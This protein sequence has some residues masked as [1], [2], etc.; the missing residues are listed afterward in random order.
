[1]RTGAVLAGD[2]N[3]DCWSDLVFT[4]GAIASG[5]LM[6]YQNRAGAGF[7]QALLNVTATS[8]PFAGAGIADLDG[9]Y[10]LDLALGNLLTGDTRTY[11]G[12]GAGGFTLLQSLPMSRSTFGFAFG[13]YSGDEWPDVFAAHWDIEPPPTDSPA[14]LINLGTGSA[15][16]DG[17]LV[18]MDVAAG[19]TSADLPQDFALSP[20]FVDLNDDQDADLLIAADFATSQVLQNTGTQSYSVITSS[21]PLS[22]QNAS[23]H[24]IAD[25]DNDGLWD[26]F[27]ASVHGPGDSRPWPWGIQGNKLYFGDNSFPFLIAAGSATGTED[28]EWPWGVCA[29]DFDNDGLTDL[30]VETGFGDAPPAVMA[31]ESTDPFIV[32]INESLFDKQLTR[33][34]LFINQGNRTFIDQASAWGID[35]PTNGRG[36]A[37]LDYDRDGDIDIAI[38]QNSGPALLY[39]NQHSADDGNHFLSLRLL[40]V[41]PNTHAIGA[42]VTVEAGGQTQ[43]QQVSANSNFLGQD[44]YDLHFGLGQETTIDALTVRWP[45]GTNESY[46]QMPVNKFMG[47]YDPRM[48]SYPTTA[49]L[50]RID[51]AITAALGYVDTPGQLASDI[52]LGLSWM[53]R[54]HQISLPYSPGDV[55]IARAVDFENQ[56]R[57][58]EAS[59]LR[60]W[61]RSFDPLYQISQSDYNRLGSFDIATFAGVYCHQ[62]PLVDSNILDIADFAALGGYDNTHALLALVW[63]I[64]ND[65]VM[66]PA[67]D[68]ALLADVVVDVYRIADDNGSTVVDDLRIEAMAFLAAAG[69]HDLIEAAWVD[70]VLDA[71]LPDGG[72]KGDPD[73]I[74]A[75][76]HTTGLALW[77]LLQLAEDSKVLT[78]YVAQTWDE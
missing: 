52:L 30:F 68:K 29:Q 24:A 45:D 65:C 61:R 73:D 14:L 33:A 9:D 20:G 63:A 3:G 4:T 19:T 32:Q 66:P 70:Q 50:N 46:L 49:R 37:C 64:D 13:D 28:A 2:V 6:V 40:S 47:L 8:N 15:L 59:Q 69:R 23:G 18:G 16:A 26:W 48:L 22:D 76:D 55:L 25:F 35:N 67:F 42:V 53:V 5:Q 72:W 62:I 41:S 7:A 44:A 74:D 78:G 21:A 60:A 77:L 31:S 58:D 11:R 56:G 43:M 57:T 39:E 75:A 1:M 17:S 10:R 71:Q 34:R 27:V 51:A 54:M 38:A 12:D 36:V